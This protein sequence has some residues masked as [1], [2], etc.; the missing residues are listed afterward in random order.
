MLARSFKKKYLENNIKDLSS[1][2]TRQRTEG[3]YRA[4]RCQF[5][6]T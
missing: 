5:D 6:L 1:Q 4:N 3:T 2:C